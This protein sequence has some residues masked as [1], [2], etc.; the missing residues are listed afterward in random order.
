MRA[1]VVGGD[2]LIGAAVA[3]AC[4]EHGLA[5]VA[6]TRRPGEINSLARPYLDLERPPRHLPACDVAFLCAGIK[7]FR[8]CEGNAQSWRVNVDGVL[9]VGRRLLRQM[10]VPFIVY[11][12]TSAVEWLDTAY[13]RQRAMVEGGLLAMS[14]ANDQVAIVR[15]D[16]FTAETAPELAHRM[17]EI[18]HAR[19]DGIHHWVETPVM[20]RQSHASLRNTAA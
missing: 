2:G 18:A 20:V 16:K 7:G 15:A 17:I 3:K 13:A 1:L 6:T 9:A 5:V 12:S 4:R 19:A 11:V 8:E 10:D 14:D